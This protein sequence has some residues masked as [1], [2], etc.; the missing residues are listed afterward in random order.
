MTLCVCRSEMLSKVCGL[1]LLDILEK[2]YDQ[3]K[4]NAH[5]LHYRIVK[6]FCMPFV[7]TCVRVVKMIKVVLVVNRTRF[8]M[9]IIKALNKVF[10]CHLW[11]KHTNTHTHTFSFPPITHSSRIYERWSVLHS[12]KNQ[13]STFSMHTWRCVVAPNQWTGNDEVN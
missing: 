2:L 4:I 5:T 12:P 3:A 11:Q 8:V 6:I 1:C 7:F 9:S 13:Y 10:C